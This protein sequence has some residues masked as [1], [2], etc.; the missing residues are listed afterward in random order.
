MAN[1]IQQQTPQTYLKTIGVIHLAL[2]LGQ[3]MFGVLIICQTRQS[4]LFIPKAN[5]PFF[6]VA[7]ILTITAI[8]GGTFWFK[9]NIDNATSKYSLK[10]KLMAYQT[11]F[12]KRFALLDG[13]SLFAIVVSSVRG[14]L[15]YLLIAGAIILF[16]LVL[17]PT[18]D[19]IENDLNL[20]YDDKMQF[21]SSEP[22]E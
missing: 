16:M 11:A 19:K 2:I 3:V 22:L 9:Q 20:S 12:I 6:I 7:I 13:A 10:Q 1:P 8:A 15:F 17:R 14:N 21:D 18:K 4:I 5:D